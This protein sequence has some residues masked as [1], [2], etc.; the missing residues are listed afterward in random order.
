M[1]VTEDK[2]RDMADFYGMSTLSMKRIY[3]TIQDFECVSTGTTHDAERC[4]KIISSLDINSMEKTFLERDFNV[5]LALSEVYGV[6]RASSD[7]DRIVEKMYEHNRKK[8]KVIRQ[9]NI[10]KL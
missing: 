8:V 9:S 1:N 7:I 3:D 6:N 2:L 10:I 5:A 4:L